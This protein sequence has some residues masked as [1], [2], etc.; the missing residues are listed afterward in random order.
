MKLLDTSAGPSVRPAR[1]LLVNF[2]AAWLVAFMSTAIN[3][4]LP[5][6][7]VEF[8][9][10]AVLLGWL[11]LAY[12]LAS[13]VFLLTFG[14]VGDRYG[15]RRLFLTGLV[16]F[17]CCSI[18]MVFAGSYL[19]LVLLRIGQGL[20]GAMIFSTS[21]AMI[22]QAYPPGR[23]GFA[24]G[25]S[26]A[27]AYLG[28]TTGPVIGGVIVHNIG[29]RDLFL[30]TGCFALGALGL[31][32][33]LLRGAD[34]KAERPGRFDWPG[35]VAWGISL[36]LFLI[37]LS[38]LPLT[39]GVVLFVAGLAGIGFFI[40]WE[41]RARS[42]LIVLRLFRG[43]RVF[44]FSNLASLISYLSIWGTTFLMSLYLQFVKGLNPQTAGIVMIAGVALQCLVS[45]FGGRL[46][47]RF[48][49]RWLA[50]FG[51][52]IYTVGALLL[53][54]VGAK[55]SFG[56]IILGLCLLGF[57]YAFFAG[58]NQ[59]CIMGCVEP[60]Y[61]GFASALIGTVR[62]VGNALSIAVVTLIMALVVGRHDIQPADYPR[63]LTAT[64]LSFAIFTGLS[65]V[66]VVASLVRGKM[67]AH[68]DPAAEAPGI[69]VG[70][71]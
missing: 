35:S 59:S 22:T 12:V 2:I 41:L 28:Q 66:A 51:M 54:F 4:A 39:K 53:S 40:W 10:N 9:L 33:W 18:A 52:G 20:G 25:M 17:A 32:L 46:S 14:K 1:V 26:V 23:R 21:V 34:W 7:Q 64:R 55:T 16:L 8:H 43:N 49:P 19:P 36:S 38:W 71:P 67:P 24:M 3:I 69:A 5:S 58:P 70:E 50:S 60:R 47:D 29:W 30:V 6:I 56:Y 44:A 27:A 65:A 48:D 57:G 11:P 42:P 68:A 31:D 37:G 63:L 45:P 15:R 13:A 61:L 62:M